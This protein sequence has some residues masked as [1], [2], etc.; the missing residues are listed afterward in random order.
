[1][2]MTYELKIGEFTGPLDALLELIEARKLEITEVSL[3]Q[4]TDDFLKYLQKL[5]TNAPPG[6]EEQALSYLR[7]LADF[8]QVASRLIFIKS[9]SLLPEMAVREEEETE[10]KDLEARLKAYRDF[11]PA[12]RHMAAL[13]AEG[14]KELVRP[15]F[16]H[17]AAFIAASGAPKNI[18]YTGGNVSVAAL[19]AALRKILES[20]EAI[21][22]QST[23]IREHIV[24]L[25]Q[26][27]N[28]VLARLRELQEKSF[29]AFSG[30]ESRG[31]II[32]TFL[33]LLHL[34]RDQ[35]ISLEQESHF[36]D[37]LVR[38]I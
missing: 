15:Y 25:E 3:A 7:L 2:A 38:K 5:R 23:V 13:W 31:E 12:L 34:A 21:V 29:V 14:K 37:I 30:T 27:I 33:A 26:R 36:S 1:M 20:L 9:K 24:T 35:M 16:L 22:A 32:V 8:I 10:I 18:F 19:E 11:K 4:V 28:E 6:D 17:A